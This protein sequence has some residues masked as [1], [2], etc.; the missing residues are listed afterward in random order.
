[1]YFLDICITVALIVW[2]CL[3]LLFKLGSIKD[4]KTK[5]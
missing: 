2:I 3:G 4:N 1:M 5:G